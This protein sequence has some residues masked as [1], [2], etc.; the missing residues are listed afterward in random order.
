MG[1]PRPAPFSCKPPQSLA[2]LVHPKRNIRRYRR[3]AC[4]ASFSRTRPAART[5]RRLTITTFHKVQGTWCKG[6]IL[7]VILGHNAS[8]KSRR[9]GKRRSFPD[10]H[11]TAVESRRFCAMLCMAAGIHFQ[12]PFDFRTRAFHDALGLSP[13]AEG[14]LESRRDNA[15]CCRS[16][17][18]YNAHSTLCSSLRSTSDNR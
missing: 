2:A 4:N 3:T 15:V 7:I 9:Q 5:T 14:S 8:L 17:D 18:R 10:R 11:T 6:S 1:R 13:A 16:P 12:Y